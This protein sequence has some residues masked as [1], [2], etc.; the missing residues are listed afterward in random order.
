MQPS[1]K[2][3]LVNTRDDYPIKRFLI[4]HLVTISTTCNYNRS[5]NGPDSM[6]VGF[7]TT[8]AT[9]AY[10]HLSCEFKS[11]PWRGVLDTTLGDKVYQLFVAG[12]WFLF[13]LATNIPTW[14]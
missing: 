14:R 6:V 2:Q 9:S 13:V 1:L 7:I 12:W 10:H 11:R 8:C 3:L 5:R 4:V